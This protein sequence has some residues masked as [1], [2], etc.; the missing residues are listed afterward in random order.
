MRTA[1]L[2]IEIQVALMDL[3]TYAVQ[4]I[5]ILLASIDNVVY[6]ASAQVTTLNVVIYYSH[7]DT[8]ACKA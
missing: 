5:V 4:I 1:L 3:C 6:A 7:A 8:A 2:A